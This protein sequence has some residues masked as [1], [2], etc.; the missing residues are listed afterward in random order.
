M[1]AARDWIARHRKLIVGVLGFT[2]TWAIQQYGADNPWV[3]L[4]VGA[5]TVAGIYGA[6]NRPA[7]A[8]PAPPPGS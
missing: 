3:A 2:L 4:A 8:K 5:A 1:T 6:P 7:P